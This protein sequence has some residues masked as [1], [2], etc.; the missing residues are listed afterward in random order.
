V[1]HLGR[2]CWELAGVG[3]D[4]FTEAPEEV[5][6]HLHADGDPVVLAHIGE[7]SLDLLAQM[8]SD[9]IRRLCAAE[10]VLL[11]EQPLV[12]LGQAGAH[13][14]G[15]EA[16]EEAGPKVI[17]GEKLQAR[18]RIWR[19]IIAPEGHG[20]WANSFHYYRFMPAIWGI[21]NDEPSLDLISAGP[22]P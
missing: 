12:V 18:R 7:G 3:G 15:D 5:A 20:P 4:E 21:H 11:R 19:R 6:G 13:A 1:E 10:G 14:L 9:P 16:L 22:I 2:V 8:P 17:H